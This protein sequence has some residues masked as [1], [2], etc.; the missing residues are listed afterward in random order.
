MIIDKPIV[1]PT[2]LYN[3][4]QTAEALHVSRSTVRRYEEQGC[5]K[6]RI[7]KAGKAKVTTGADIIKCW[8]GM[9]SIK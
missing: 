2:G 9:Y 8:Q 3:Q 7:R 6:F 1:N 4:K 5:L